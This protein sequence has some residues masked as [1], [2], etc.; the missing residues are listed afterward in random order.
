MDKVWGDFHSVNRPRGPSSTS[1]E[2]VLGDWE[3]RG[4]ENL[5]V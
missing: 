2:A 5:V 4:R 3:V 1:A